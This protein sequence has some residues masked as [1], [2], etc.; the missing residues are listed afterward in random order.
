MS[1]EHFDVLVVG[2]GISG[3]G[4]GY[5]LQKRC[6][7]K[8]YVIL[9]NRDAIGG[10][11]DLFR[12]PGI[13]SDS[14]MYT[15]GYAFKPWTEQKAIADGPSIWKY[16]NE[17]AREYGIDKHIRFKHRVVRGSWDRERCALDGRS[18]ARRRGQALHCELHPHVRGLL[19]IRARLHA[20]L[21]R[22]GALQ[23]PDHPAATLAGGPRLYGQARRRHRLGRDRGD[24]GAGDDRQGRARDDAAAHAHLHDLAAV[25]DALG[26]TCAAAFSPQLAYDINRGIRTFFQQFFFRFA[27]NR[28]EAFK[29]RLMKRIEEQLPK[30][31]IEKHFTPPYKPWEQ[32][33]CLVPDNDMFEAIRSGKASVV[34]D[35][36][37]EFTEKG[38]KLKSGQEMEADIIVAATG[39]RAANARRRRS[40]RRRRARSIPARRYTYKGAMYP[41]CRTSSRCSA[42]PTPPGRCAP[43][44]SSNT[45]AA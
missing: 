26:R 9:E 1:S 23:R 31:T 16:V 30:E 25:V 36:I 3:I 39:P 40:V 4:A 32:R 38:I 33:L 37:E 34:T 17:T 5:H 22:H 11:W 41:T 8:S 44:S 14:D 7:G 28:P 6:P 18:R 13:R 29:K 43:I 24:V 12:Y 35:H 10:T 15:L 2:A 27:R 19:Q 42:T 21:Q 45:P 20:R